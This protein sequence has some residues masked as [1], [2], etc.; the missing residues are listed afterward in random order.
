M[1]KILER[2]VVWENSNNPDVLA[3][4]KVEIERCFEGE[5][6]TVLDPFA[7]GGSIPLEAQRLGLKVVAGDLNPVAVL[8]NKAMVEIPPRFAKQPP[9][10]PDARNKMTTWDRGQ[11][12]ADDIKAY[13][14]WMKDEAKRKIG[15]LY[16]DVTG[17]DGRQLTPIAWIWARTVRSPDPAW[18]GHVPLVKSWT[19]RKAKKDKPE[20]WVEPVI[21]RATQT[22][23]Y[24]V[25]YGLGGGGGSSSCGSFKPVVKRGNGTCVATGAAIP[26]EYI[27]AEGQEGR[28]GVHLLAVVAEGDKGRVYL[29]PQVNGLEI[30]QAREVDSVGWKPAGR[31]PPPGE[32]LGFTVQLYGFEEWWQLFTTRQLT[33]L[34]TFSDLLDEVRKQIVVDAKDA[35]FRDDETRLRDGGTGVQAYADAVV[36]YLA[37][38]IDKL[39]DLGNS[40]CR[41]E[42]LA[43]C[44]RNLFSKQ[45]IAMVWDFAEGNPLG[46]SSGSWKVVLD[47]FERTFKSKAWPPPNF[48]EVCV[49]QA[50]ARFLVRNTSGVII[51]TD[52]PYYDNIGYAGISDFFYVWIK[53]NLADVW[54]EECKTLLTPKS[55]EL[56]ADKSRHES[57][58]EAREYFEGGMAEFM[59]E[60]VAKQNQNVPA[61]IYYAYKATET[62][63]HGEVVSTGWSTFLQAVVDAGLQVT[64]TWPLRTESSNRQR[65]LGS[66]TLASSIVL[67]CRPR[68]KTAPLATRSEFVAALQNELP[69]AVKVLLSGNIAPVDLP[70][71]TIG[72]GI[73][74]FSRYARVVE[75]NG[76]PMPVSDALAIINKELDEILH[77]EASEFDA[78]TR[79][80][81]VWYAQYGFEAASF[82]DAE[83]IAKAKD[84]AVEGVIKAGIGKATAGKFHLYARSK[85]D[86]DWD[87]TRDSR[88]VVWEALQHLAARLEVSESQA[89]ELLASLSEASAETCDRA[90]QLA[91]L[92]HKIAN[93]NGWNEEASVYNGL[94]ATWPKLLANA[95]EMIED[96][97]WE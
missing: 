14:T 51:S 24:R 88:L 16:P 5:P 65:S 94:A 70:Q 48:S 20:V 64:A 46:S 33:A 60:V 2:L 96:E 78:E 23:N 1:F 11:G 19:L 66:N 47:G 82:G 22:I 36:T 97:L 21:D 86:P 29:S 53:Q 63:K 42:P 74:V 6:P 90:R 9:V 25:N 44:P 58:E 7:G 41:W 61:T 72:P 84:T 43:Q 3:E 34:V 71:S 59:H 95:P 4:A 18:D 8:L 77:G 68:P 10:H 73:S 92:L 38:I 89:A 39:A 37:L 76:E 26:L 28:M 50:D 57:K 27:K 55:E 12:L 91:Y 67:A 30:F 35:G 49:T 85:L 31:L 81:L 83:S 79:F 62:S 15:H 69:G 13:G 32:G 40:L 17:P 56:I 75:A 45:A 52:P 54:P 93:D 87:P 80:A